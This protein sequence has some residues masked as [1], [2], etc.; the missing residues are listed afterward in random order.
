MDK[1]TS[2][3]WVVIGVLWLLPL[4]GLDFLGTITDGIAAWLIGIGV[5][6]IG[7]KG[8]FNK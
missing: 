7:L 8:A 2:W 5:L 6:V 4:I 1:L 3:I